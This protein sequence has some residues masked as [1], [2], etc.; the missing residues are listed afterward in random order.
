MNLSLMVVCISFH[1]KITIGL[2]KNFKKQAI[3]IK[4]FVIKLIVPFDTSIIKKHLP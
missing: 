3:K 1:K 4:S 2:L